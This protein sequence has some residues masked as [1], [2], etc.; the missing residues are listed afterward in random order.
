MI[1][2]KVRVPGSGKCQGLMLRVE[3]DKSREQENA[4][5]ASKWIQVDA[6]GG[7]YMSMS[8]EVHP[9]MNNTQE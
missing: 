1:R 8:L 3:L 6:W 4:R 7:K 9:V 5:K 2:P